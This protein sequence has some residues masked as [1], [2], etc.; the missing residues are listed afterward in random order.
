M[1]KPELDGYIKLA[2]LE[3]PPAGAPVAAPFVRYEVIHFKDI[4]SYKISEGALTILHKDWHRIIPLHIIHGMEIHYNSPE[5]LKLHTEWME[6]EH[7]NHDEQNPDKDCTMC[8]ETKLSN[9]PPHFLI[10]N[11]NQDGI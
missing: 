8:I 1:E 2:V 11:A 6:A 9:N 7:R 5:F 3:Y 10:F 4:E